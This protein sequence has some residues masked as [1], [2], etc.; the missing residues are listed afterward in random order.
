MIKMGGAHA[1]FRFFISFSFFWLGPLRVWCRVAAWLLALAWGVLLGVFF[2][3][4]KHFSFMVLYSNLLGSSFSMGFF[5]WF[6]LFLLSLSHLRGS[7][8]DGRTGRAEGGRRGLVKRE[9]KYYRIHL[10][11]ACP[12]SLPPSLSPV[13]VVL[14][15]C[16]VLCMGDML[17]RWRLRLM[18][19]T[20]KRLPGRSER[21]S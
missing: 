13:D 1:F 9:S 10:T 18:A 6:R 15:C 14:C 16:A 11:G 4:C 3:N 19:G 17:P 21:L 12:P 8:L 2:C 5:F 7:T 20:G